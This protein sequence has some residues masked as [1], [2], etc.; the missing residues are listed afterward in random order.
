MPEGSP[1]HAFYYII[2]EAMKTRSNEVLR[3]A[4]ALVC[5]RCVSETAVRRRA[6]K[7]MM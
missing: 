5:D 3:D 1:G 6:V 7:L 2:I 4:N